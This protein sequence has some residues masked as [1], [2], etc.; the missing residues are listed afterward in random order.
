MAMLV[1]YGA[2]PATTRLGDV[3][4]VFGYYR[5]R[6]GYRVYAGMLP[7][8]YPHLAGLLLLLPALWVAYRRRTA[9][10]RPLIVALAVAALG[11][12]VGA[13]HAGAF[14]YFWMTLGLFP[15]CAVALGWPGIAAMWPKASRPIAIGLWAGLLIVAIQYRLEMFED[16]QAVQRDTFAFID[17]NFDRTARGFHADGG[18]FC[19]RDPQP[20]PVYLHEHVMRTFGGPD[21]G[22]QADL[23]VAEF[24]ARPVTFMIEDFLLNPFPAKVKR[25]WA[26]HYVPYYG[27]ASVPGRRL[28]G[29][30]GT[31]VELDIIVAGDYRWSGPGG[32]SIDGI[33]L[34][35]GAT[36]PLSAGAHVTMLME[37]TPGGVLALA[38]PEPP[39]PSRAPFHAQGP[40]A[41]IAGASR[42][43]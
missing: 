31:Q 18:L 41:E 30:A 1:L 8:L 25:F 40:I 4:N 28:R 13:F 10:V 15:A 12:A 2:V 16:T 26:T 9:Q 22:R 7:T 42:A 33:R 29:A 24:R 21:G 20:F 3:L 23:L 34:Q 11:L 37:D 35:P 32:I 27:A 38:L 19:R 14:P 36:I 43:W 39:R 5:E 6:F 17:R